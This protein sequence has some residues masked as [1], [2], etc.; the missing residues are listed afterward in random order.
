MKSTFLR[1]LCLLC[2][3]LLMGTV[4]LTGCGE[5]TPAAESDPH[6]G[7]NH[8]TESPQSTA[9]ATKQHNHK[10]P[11]LMHVAYESDENNTYALII[12]DCEG[13]LL[14]EKKGLAK[15]AIS[16]QINDYVV[17]LSWVLN[18]N[19]GG[20]ES[21]Y[22]DRKTCRVSD[23]I[24]G[25]QATDGTRIVFTEIKNG[26]LNVTVRDLFDQNGYSKTTEVK[27]AYTKGDYTVLG[28]VMMEHDQ[29]NV[30]YLTDKDGGHRFSSFNLYEKGEKDSAK[31]T[32]KTAK[33]TDAKK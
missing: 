29:V 12:K 27:E 33:Q 14:L 32:E 21:L 28:T 6:A 23:V 8:G 13:N 11:A 10:E 26:V 19:P 24:A 31:T 15:K 5:E 4:A 2:A 1:V 30:S 3:L 17:C 9:P 7:H 25:E 18:S 22:I 16:Q 20:Y